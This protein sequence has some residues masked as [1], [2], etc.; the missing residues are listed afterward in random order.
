MKHELRAHMVPEKAVL[1]N[2]TVVRCP[3]SHG[4]FI[5]TAEGL[6]YFAE[7]WETIDLLSAF[8]C[9]DDMR[10]LYASLS[11]IR[12]STI[13]KMKKENENLKEFDAQLLA[14]KNL[15]ASAARYG[16]RLVPKQQEKT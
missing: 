1:H 7:A 3:D 14:L 6:I 2:C 15:K 4:V 16:F 13:K 8:N 11:G 10:R 12:F 5:R 9:N